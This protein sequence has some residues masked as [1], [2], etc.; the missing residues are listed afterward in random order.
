MFKDPYQMSSLCIHRLCEEHKAYNG[1]L[2]LAVDF[3]DTVYDYHKAGHTYT[4][5]IDL[6]RQAQEAGWYIVLFTGSPRERW[7]EQVLYLAQC[8]I[9]VD[10]VNENAIK[11]PF[12]NDGKIYYNLLLDDR[13]GLGEALD[14]LDEVL[15]RTVGE[16][17]EQDAYLS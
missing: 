12:G 7:R 5:A 1:K 13:A 11:L 2:I 8:G 3:D 10:S 15:Q 4:R 16:R 14:I 17:K 6:I 9:Q